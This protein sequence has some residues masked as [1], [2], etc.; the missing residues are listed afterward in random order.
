MMHAQNINQFEKAMPKIDILGLNVVYAD[1]DDNIAWWGCALIPKRPQGLNPKRYIDGA[2]DTMNHMDF[3]DFKDNPQSTNPPEGYIV[4]ANN[5]PTAVNGINY[6]G[7][8]APGYRAQRLKD[9]IKAQDKWDVESMKQLHVDNHSDRDQ[10]LSKLIY[11]EAKIGEKEIAMMDVLDSWDGNYDLNSK[12]AIIFNRL[13][14]FILKDA[15]IDELGDD[16]F[17][18]LKRTY[19]F[20]SGI[21]PLISNPNS[22]WWDNIKT[23]QKESRSDVFNMAI[24]QTYESLSKQLTPDIESWKWG[25]VHQLEFV[26]PIGRKKP[27]DKIFNL[28]PFPIAG[29]NEVVDKE[30]FVYGEDAVYQVQSGPAMRLLMDFSN[31]NAAIGVIPTGQSG[32]FMSPHYNDQME[33]FLNG[34][35]RKQISRAA[36]LPDNHNQVWF[37][38]GN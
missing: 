34:K 33:L 3:Y 17:D 5:A 36:D 8:Y 24:I 29:G 21:E 32:N 27:M 16:V 12:G 25:N 1:H 19:V 23:D 38:P 35:Y 30:G 4:T 9:L 15:M 22:I 7:Y 11:S 26:H 37:I 13:I 20:K 10:R 18:K 6:P 31:P 14:Y 28:G 2:N